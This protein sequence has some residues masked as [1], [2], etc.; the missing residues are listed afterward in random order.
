MSVPDYARSESVIGARKLAH[1]IKIQG[2]LHG[3][4]Q[5]RHHEIDDA[6]R[7]YEFAMVEMWRTQNSPDGKFREMC[8][9]CRDLLQTTPLPDDPGEKIKH[10]LK[11]FAYSYLGEKWEDMR[12]LLI[13]CPG[14]WDTPDGDRWDHKVMYGIY[15]AILYLVRKKEW[16]DLDAAAKHIDALRADQPKYEEAFLSDVRPDDRGLAARDLAAYYHL[17][18]AVDALAQFM[19]EGG[20]PSNVRAKVDHHL[21]A[22]LRL[23]DG[24][25]ELEVL[26]VILKAAFGKMIDNSIWNVAGTINSR[27]TEFIRTLTGPNSKRP[28]YE[29][30]YPQRTAIRQHLLDP[31]IR[32][33]VVT[34]PTSSGKTLLAEFRMLQAI[35][36]FPDG[37]IV[38]VAP[39]RALVNQIT[40]RLRQD[41]GEPPLNVRV[42]KMSGA[43]DVNSFEG[44]VLDERGFDILVTTPEKLN[45]LIRDASNGLAKDIVLSIIDEA[46]NMSSKTR[47]LN[48]EML[49]SNIRSDCPGSALL[50]LTPFIPNHREVAEWL[51]PDNPHSISVEIDW[52]RPNDRAVGICYAGGPRGNVTVRFKPLITHNPDMIADGEMVLGNVPDADIVPSL[53]S[54]SRLAAAAASAMSDHKTLIL[55]QTIPMAWDMA[56]MLYN[57]IPDGVTDAERDTVSRYVESELGEGFELAG[58]IRKGIGV[59][60]AGLPDDI[61]ELIEWLMES[62]SLRVMVA[63]TTLAQGMNF[64]VDAVLFSSHSYRG[65]GDMPA[66]D[67]WNI[68]GRAGRVDQRSMGLV[69]IMA[70]SGPKRSK[71]ARY[72][73]NQT[74][75]LASRLEYLVTEATAGGK[76]LSLAS[77]AENPDWSAF[78]QYVSH[79]YKQAKSLEGFIASAQSS[80]E[81]TYGFAQLPADKR[82][83]LLDAVKE[84]AENLKD[85]GDDLLRLSDVTGLSVHSVE[86]ALGAVRGFGRQ[87]AE[88]VMSGRSD[89]LSALMETVFNEIPETKDTIRDIGSRPPLDGERIGSLVEEWMKGT[90]LYDISDKIFGAH[91]AKSLSHCVR[92]L[93]TKVTNSASWGFAALQNIYSDADGTEGQVRAT[94]LPAKVYYGV[95]TDAA[96]LMRLNGVPRAVAPAMGRIYEKEHTTHGATPDGALRWIADLPESEWARVLP[97]GGLMS[98]AEYQKIWKRLAGL[99]V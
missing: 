14:V 85:G 33:T 70:Q 16:G 94:N 63:T 97:A 18:G 39:T 99:D 93:Y 84:Y 44:N 30:L 56:E 46:H 5:E 83:I 53:M 89:I 61:R 57:M 98:G 76:P 13:E 24:A 4:E 19:A 34:F 71:A 27:A 91:D 26:L 45:L 36:Q 79:M 81:R 37:K 78:L 54:H 3:D 7:M 20:E 86:K 41:L 49:I 82:R 50:L 88:S 80:L 2:Y 12:R 9:R 28:V 11:L 25:W 60:H 32:A 51:N 65:H 42:E 22:A 77:C 31:A 17:A 55:A 87:W 69:G 10:V 40:S 96:V 8:N 47:G 15:K 64:P 35:N 73:Q 38:Y 21:D 67:F 75:R 1:R 68:A 58:Y 23:A 74:E 29:L 43:I 59:H 92:M 6:V 48:L 72:V 95:D 66:M 62:G 52:W 90:R